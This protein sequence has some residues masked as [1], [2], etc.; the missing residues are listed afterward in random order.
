MLADCLSRRRDLWALFRG[1]F[2]ANVFDQEL[3][4][5]F[6]FD[7]VFKR[8]RCLGDLGTGLRIGW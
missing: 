5:S 8:L 2:V 1:A 4:I 3:F 7:H 6:L